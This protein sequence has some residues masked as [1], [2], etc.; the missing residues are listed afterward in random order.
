MAHIDLVA[1]RT[2]TKNQHD[3]ITARGTQRAENPGVRYPY[4]R[5]WRGLPIS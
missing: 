1:G 4:H 2:F 3:R 5:S